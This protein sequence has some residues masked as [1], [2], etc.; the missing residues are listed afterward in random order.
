ITS[1]STREYVINIENH[2]TQ[3]RSY[4]F[5]ETITFQGCQYDE[6]IR[7]VPST[8]MLSVDQVFVMYDR[9][10]QL[11]RYAMSNKIGDIN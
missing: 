7:A 8:Q 9:S 6:A 2:S 4:K 10:E 5:R 3:S 11:L 1:S